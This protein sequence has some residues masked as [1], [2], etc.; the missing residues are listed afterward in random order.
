MYLP[1]LNSLI[2][3]AGLLAAPLLYS[4]NLG[5]PITES[6]LTDFDLIAGPDGAGFPDGSGSVQQGKI[7]YESKCAACHGLSGQGLSASTRLVGGDMQSEA[8]PIKTVGSFWPE[9]STLFDFIRRAMPANAPKSLTDAEVY[10][11]TAY[12]LFLNGLINEN[13]IL[14]SA[15]LQNIVMP[16]AAGF[17]DQSHLH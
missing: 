2:L 1:K 12:V 6:Q 11:T 4:Q 14:D 3:I 17:I 8:N 7:V 10:Q 16:N 5:Q 13:E 9:A 15:V